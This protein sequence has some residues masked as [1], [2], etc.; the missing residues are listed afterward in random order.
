MKYIK[1]FL[2]FIAAS[3]VFSCQP[4][5]A[6]QGTATIGFDNDT[7]W[8]NFPNG[9][10]DVNPVPITFKGSSNL[11]PV[12]AT[13]EVVADYDGDGFPGVEDQD[14]RITSLEVFFGEPSDYKDSIEANPDYSASITKNIEFTYP[15]SVSARLDEMRVKLRIASWSHSDEIQLSNGEVVVKTTIPDI[16]RLV[17][18]Y[19]ATGDLYTM[20]LTEVGEVD[21][22]PVYDTTFVASGEKANF[23]VRVVAQENALAVRGLFCGDYDPVTDI[24]SGDELQGN[25]V[26]EFTV[27]ISDEEARELSMTLGSAN[28]ELNMVNYYLYCAEYVTGEQGN[29]FL[30][31]DVKG[32]YDSTYSFFTFGEE[33]EDC[34]FTIWRYS[35]NTTRRDPMNMRYFVKNL[36]FEKKADL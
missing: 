5:Q 11:W 17:G 20:E 21:D 36:R 26:T 29:M 32:F 31:G 19:D 12:K 4:E 9:E 15:D 25:F 30:T 35:N 1:L 8:Y 22:K 27:N 14:Y 10:D 28:S 23:P 34:Y 18:I 6:Y 24:N 13:I 16:Q 3:F 33:V 7:I 2:V